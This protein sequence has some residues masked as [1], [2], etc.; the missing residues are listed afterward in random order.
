M[1]HRRLNVSALWAIALFGAV[2]LSAHAAPVPFQNRSAILAFPNAE[3]TS[4]A[5]EW[6]AAAH[7]T[8]T[9]PFAAI[10]PSPGHPRAPL[11]NA[12]AFWAPIA[13]PLAAP[14][15]DTI[16]KL[17]GV[18]APTSQ[19]IVQLA[20]R[21]TVQRPIVAVGDGPMTALANAGLTTGIANRIV[22]V[23]Q[24]PNSGF[25][26]YRPSDPWA[27]AWLL[28]NTRT[29]AIRK[30]NEDGFERLVKSDLRDRFPIEDPLIQT[31]AAK[32][33]ATEGVPLGDLAP[34]L[35]LITPEVEDAAQ[36]LRLES[37]GADGA[38]KT[39]DDPR[40]PI[41]VINRSQLG[42]L[43][44]RFL[45]LLEQ[46]VE[47]RQV[48]HRLL[49][50]TDLSGEIDDLLALGRVL[51]APN[52]R[53]VG[54]TSAHDAATLDAQPNSAGSSYHFAATALLEWNARVPSAEGAS[55]PMSAANVPIDSPALRLIIE[56]AAAATPGDPLKILAMGPLTNVASALIARPDL[57]PHL[58]VWFAGAQFEDGVWGATDANCAADPVA[59][60]V[61]FDTKGL[62]TRILNSAAAG[63]LIMK[64]R[65]F[66]SA[67]AN[68]GGAWAWVDAYWSEF[69]QKRRWADSLS[70]ADQWV[71]RSGALVEG[72]LHPSLLSTMSTPRPNGG[73]PIV[74]ATELQSE[75]ML[76][77]F[78]QGL[79]GER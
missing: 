53:L 21:S 79:R 50:D 54:V 36:R 5:T 34:Y 40:G 15:E 30:D 45:A 8:G 39:V 68:Q 23:F 56:Q 29:L 24:I 76:Q 31:L 57:I 62:K 58:E 72:L 38:L 33:G 22:C 2:A 51:R 17:K 77:S 48:V 52:A 20:T 41:F 74:V 65:A 25:E 64:R 42:P 11:A 16:Q 9:L 43:K 47:Q 61:V 6:V 73:Q 12:P 7:A 4:V 32:L 71:L 75:E 28:K 1:N 70:S 67:T 59:L 66:R 3:E 13:E 55:V 18:Y 44:E 26:A 49:I 78:L 69:T 46:K 37:V 19:R 63:S 27:S 35:A 14:D 60:R 10:I